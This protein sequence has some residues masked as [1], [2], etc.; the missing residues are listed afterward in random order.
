L[1]IPADVLRDLHRR[2]VR[3]RVFEEEAG[4]LMESARIPG[5]LHLY[6]GEE[7]VGAGVMVHLS[8]Q[9]Q[10]T[11]THRGHGHL[12]AK[13]GDF[14][15]MYAEL[16]GKATGYNKGKGGSMHICDMDR[17]M[18][19]ANGIVGGGPPIAI[20]AAFSNQFRGTENVAVCFFGDGA[21][22]EGSFHEAANMAALYK[23]PCVFVCENNGYGEFTAQ[24]N[25]QA[26]K[27]VADRANGYGMPGV[28]VDGMDAIAVYEAAGEAIA[29]A[30][31]GEGPTLLECK[32]YRFYDHVGVRGMG[33]SYR[34][35]EEVMEWRKRDPIALL[36]QQLV[37]MGVMTGEEA[38]A[39]HEQ[40]I[41]EAREAIEFAEQSPYPDVSELLTDVYATAGKDT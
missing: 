4:K 26:I 34:T 12:V 39:L 21:S 3:I 40:V 19:G 2:M 16:F 10:I 14:K 35:D 8:D 23:L 31:R 20:G 27:D 18:L 38:A 28:V 17:G 13:G 30:R 25:H 37:E 24:R 33:V 32:T 1:D 29:R 11:S 9:D 22:N 6:V 5:A 7:A 36:E 15:Q 41:A